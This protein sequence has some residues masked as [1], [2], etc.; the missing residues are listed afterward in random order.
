MRISLRT[1]VLAALVGVVS[2]SVVAV[3]GAT[4][5][6]KPYFGATKPGSYAKTRNVNTVNGDV[7]EYVYTRLP[8]EDGHRAQ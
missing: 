3:G 2:A 8:D 5:W 7:S 4:R 6:K 1:A